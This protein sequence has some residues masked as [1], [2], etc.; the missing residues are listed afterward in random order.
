MNN[1][2][3]QKKIE[4]IYKRA[5]KLL[6][7]ITPL[8]FDCGELCNNKCC[9]DGYEGMYL[10]P[11]EEQ[12]LSGKTE[13]QIVNT[14]SNLNLLLCNG[15]CNRKYRPLACR[16]FPYF[17]YLDT[18]GILEVKFDLRAKSI[19]PL[20]FTDILQIVIN[21]RFIKRI[22]RVFRKLIKHK[23]FYDYL[24]NLTDEIVFL[25]KFH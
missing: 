13:N 9:K 19:C 20:Q 18:N 12:Y 22:E 5:Y 8:H 17:P 7:N 2:I 25:E 3:T 4:C 24:R 23:V 21:K 1:L 15:E 11:Y 16:I 10:F 6:N 14:N